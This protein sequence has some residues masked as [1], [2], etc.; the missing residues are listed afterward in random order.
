MEFKNTLRK[1][2]AELTEEAGAIIRRHANIAA[3]Q[4]RAAYPSGGTG[5]LARGLTVEDTGGKRFGVVVRVKNRAP[6][7]WMYEN[8]TQTRAY[9]GDWKHGKNV[10]AARPQHTFLPIAIRQRKQM[11]GELKA[12]NE[13]HGLTVSGGRG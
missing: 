11:E 4:I 5:N 10:G 2:P 9:T 1:L 3:G 8:G 13:R 12:M 7:A 6:H